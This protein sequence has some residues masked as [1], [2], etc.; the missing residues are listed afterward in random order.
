MSFQQSNTQKIN[1]EEFEIKIITS[2]PNNCYKSNTVFYYFYTVFQ[3]QFQFLYNLP[4]HK[5]S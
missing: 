4:L 2:C 3:F 1:V 5:T